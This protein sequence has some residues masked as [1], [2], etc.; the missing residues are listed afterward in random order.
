M[1]LRQLLLALACAAFAA[2]LSGCF[3]EPEEEE[4]AALR[5]GLAVKVGDIEYTVYMTRQ[6]NPAL[7]DDRGYWQGPEAEPGFALYGV[8]IQACNRSDEDDD[9]EDANYFATDDFVVVDTQ[10]N[11]YEPLETDDENVF[12]YHAT[13]LE[14]GQCIPTKG[15][16]AQQGPTA[17]AMIPFEFPLEAGENRPLELEIHGEGQEGLVELDL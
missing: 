7:A 9:L 8:F 12:H 13:E 15:S 5:E 2:S 11:E 10:G 14:P 4:G 1:G 17:G 16:L 3:L 6:L